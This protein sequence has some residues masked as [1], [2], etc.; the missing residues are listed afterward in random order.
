MLILDWCPELLAGQ[1]I[2]ALPQVVALSAGPIDCTAIDDARRVFCVLVV[3]T[4]G[5]RVWLSELSMRFAR[6]ES[7]LRPVQLGDQ[8]GVRL[9]EILD[10]CFSTYD[11]ASVKRDLTGYLLDYERGHETADA[12]RIAKTIMVLDDVASNQ[13][14]LTEESDLVHYVISQCFNIVRLG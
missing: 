2:V 1:A 13:V 9:E 10:V 4:V 8:P 7:C 5:E 11:L 3:R 12:L 6:S 14:A